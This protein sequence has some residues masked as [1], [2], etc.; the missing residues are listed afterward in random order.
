MRDLK[1]LNAMIDKMMIDADREIKEW[2]EGIK[3]RELA[4]KRRVAPGWLDSEVRVLEPAK[5]GEEKGKNVMDSIDHLQEG[6]KDG[7]GDSLV[8]KV[9][10]EGEQMDKAFGGLDIK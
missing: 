6:R 1:A 7:L 9:E 2:E 10:R 8:D 4:E 3:Q 5:R